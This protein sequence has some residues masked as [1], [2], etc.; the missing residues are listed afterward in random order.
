MAKIKLANGDMDDVSEL[1][2]SMAEKIASLEIENPM[3]V[4]IHTGGVWIAERLN[5]ILK[6]S[7]QISTLDISF[8]RDDFSRVGLN[9]EVKSSEFQESV[10]ARNI[11]LIDDVLYTGRTI[12]AAMNEIFSYGRPSTIMLGVLIDRPGRE[13]PIRADIIG[14]EMNLEPDQQVKLI[15]KKKHGKGQLQLKI[16]TIGQKS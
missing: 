2:S 9:P 7:D 4:G 1:I 14:C 11:I 15:H 5:Q 13:I 16:D 10:E 6:Y 8:Y 12:R 3:I